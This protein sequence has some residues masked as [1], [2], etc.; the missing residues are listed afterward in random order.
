[1]KQLLSKTDNN[2]SPLIARLMLGIVLFPH[3]AQ[4]LLGWFG[5]FGLSGTMDFFTHKVGLPSIV[6]FAVI[7]IEFFGSLL[8][9]A[10]LATRLLAV[11]MTGLFLGIVVTT[12]LQNGFF[13]NWYSTQPGEG[14]EYFLLAI[15]LSLSLA[16]S[17]AGAFS[18]DRIASRAL[19][20]RKLATP[21][22]QY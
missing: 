6:G 3:G 11:M 18:L 15:G 10:G 12:H 2:L 7:A 9:L 17:G 19:M 8:L 13:M 20:P 1:M 4:K 14:F 22:P 16:F 21:A 5:G